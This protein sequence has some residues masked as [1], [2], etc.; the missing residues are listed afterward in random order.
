MRIHDNAA[1]DLSSRLLYKFGIGADADGDD[2]DVEA[3]LLSAVFESDLFAL[4]L[5]GAVVQDKLNAFGF[6]L[7][8]NYGRALS[9][10]YG[11]QNSVRKVDDGY[12]A[13]A[14]RNALDA[15]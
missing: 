1:V 7:A 11:G 3:Y 10:E 12:R 8:L 5:C 4:E 13:D 15:L 9:V 6:E 14:L 2:Q